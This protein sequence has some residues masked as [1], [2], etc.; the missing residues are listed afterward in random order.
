MNT[1]R[2]IRVRF[3]PSPTGFLHV[4]GARTA[5]FNWLFARKTGG[6]FVLRIEDTDR[7]RSSEEMTK[8]ILEGLEWLG[9]GWDEGPIHQA[10][11]IARHRADALSLLERGAA[12]RCFCTPEQIEVRRGQGN[13]A[14]R[15]DRFCLDHVTAED[16]AARAEARE[17]HTIRFRVPE[18]V[19]A[20]NDV[21]HGTIEFD[22]ASIED[23][24][25]LR[26]DYTPIYNLAVVSDDAHMQISHVLRGDDH[27]SN[28]P[29]QILLYR[30]LGF[31]EPIFGHVP[32]INGQDGKR[33]SKRHGAIAV[34]E[35]R[36]RGI[37]PAA[38]VNFLALLGW[39][40]GTDQEVF[41]RDELIE[42]FTLE[43]VNKKSAIFD[44]TKLLWL[45]GQYI[46]RLSA[47][48]LFERVQPFLSERG[49]V[50]ALLA[51]PEPAWLEL[52]DVLKVR[53]RSIDELAVLAEPFFLDLPAYDE[54]AVSKHW[55]D[56]SRTVDYLAGLRVALGEVSA[57]DHD[58][59]EA[60]LRAHAERIGA[61]AGQ[62]IH[63]L[64][65]ALIGLANG[66]GIFEIAHIL[67]REQTLRRI[68]AAIATLEAKV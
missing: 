68:D 65:V 63:P 10:E 19:T 17:S 13:D 41:T 9:L 21:V 5:L 12:Y 8:A 59:L 6:T 22:N 37:L 53:A 27:I 2:G 46:V 34:G 47:A 20:W 38:M 15:Y 54:A 29:K 30:A 48:E 62:L 50:P 39:S 3:A 57:W 35:Y 51:V 18:G 25:I 23:F 40:P 64:R 67:G 28:T 7:S 1:T 60:A 45:N 31:D 32:L 4:G 44:T 56:R 61:K 52:L 42:R 55:A 33:L 36:N 11:G 49:V 26:S 16:S 58:S 24:I 43:G 14:F 66:P